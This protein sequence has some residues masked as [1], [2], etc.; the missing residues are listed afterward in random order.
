MCPV[1]SVWAKRLI[2]FATSVTTQEGGGVGGA[3]VSSFFNGVISIEE[4][5]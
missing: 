3:Y 2:V 4:E 1:K 5:K